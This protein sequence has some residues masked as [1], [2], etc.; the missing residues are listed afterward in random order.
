M[1]LLIGKTLKNARSL[2]T[3]IEIWFGYHYIRNLNLRVDYKN[4]I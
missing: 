4:R 1:N 3:E 2:M